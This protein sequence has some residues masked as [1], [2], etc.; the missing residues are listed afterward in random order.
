MPIA[1]T[2]RT[3]ERNP[4]DVGTLWTLRHR[5]CTA[6]CALLAWRQM[7]EVRVVVDREILLTER[8]RRTDDAF[9][10][11]EEWKRRLLADGWQQLVPRSHQLQPSGDPVIPSRKPAVSTSV[12]TG[13][14]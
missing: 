5:G 7:W 11:A 12:D 14:V 13:S 8:C 10:L 3:P 9:A 1:S 4:E 2:K 6:R